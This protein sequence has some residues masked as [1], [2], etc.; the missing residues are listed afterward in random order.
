M[1]TYI[2]A[3]GLYALIS[4][5]TEMT[6]CTIGFLVFD[7]VEELDFIGPLEVFNTMADIAAKADM[8]STG[9]TLFLSLSGKDVTGTRGLPIAVDYGLADAPELDVLCVPGGGGISRK[10]CNR[11]LL[12]RI[13]SKAPECTWI[14]G[15]NSGI[16]LLCAA[17][18]TANKTLAPHGSTR[19]SFT[20]PG[21]KSAEH[22]T[23]A[24]VRDG[25]LLTSTG[26]PAGIDLSL[27]L[28]GRLHSIP[29]ALA[30]QRAISHQRQPANIAL[31]KSL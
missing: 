7:D 14:A 1:M 24:Y 3:M 31:A 18:L 22:A 16:T 23:S 26:V 11:E 21:P 2:P 8:G 19:C 9:K 25:N 12:D 28:I 6:T 17:G 4:Q 27:W 30:T 29:L 15:L 10:I 20:G 5:R 13:A